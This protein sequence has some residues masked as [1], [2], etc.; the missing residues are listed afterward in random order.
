MM[1]VLDLLRSRARERQVGAAEVLAAAANRAAAGESVDHEAVDRALVDC[2]KTVD[3]FAAMC[4][5]AARRRNWRATLDRAP[6]AEAKLAKARAAAEKERAAFEATHAAWM[7]R[8]SELD[9]EIASATAVVTAARDAREELVKP[10]NVPEPLRSKLAEATTVRDAATERVA[11]INRELRDAR[12][13]EKTQREW[14][15]HKRSLNISTHVGDADD[16][17][18]AAKRA[19]KRAAELLEELKAAQAEEETAA[20]EVRSLEAAAIKS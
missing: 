17:D 3:D 11:N 14:A 18:R 19:A 4:D 10:A 6:Q 13:R 2:G 20:A 9:A 5:M 7:K 1:K 16:H 8:G 12:D 15:D